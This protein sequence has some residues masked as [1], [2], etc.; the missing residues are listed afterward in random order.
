MGGF[1]LNA[2]NEE[3][4]ANATTSPTM[5]NGLTAGSARCVAEGLGRENNGGRC[6]PA[7]VPPP[8]TR[9][10]TPPEPAD[11]RAVSLRLNVPVAK[12]PARF[13]SFQAIHYPVVAADVD[14]ATVH[15][16]A[17]DDAPTGRRRPQNFAALGIK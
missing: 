9:L 13:H 2:R 11:R 16:G 14:A 7:S 3:Y 10:S 12:D 5:A 6:M 8:S 4:D 17:G 1:Y 15:A